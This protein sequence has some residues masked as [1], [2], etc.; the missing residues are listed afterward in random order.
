[1]ESGGDDS[2]QPLNPKR[3]NGSNTT[4]NGNAAESVVIQDANAN[5]WDS[6]Q[7]IA[8]ATELEEAN[9]KFKL[10]TPKECTSPFD[11]KFDKEKGI[12]EIPLIQM[13][14]PWKTVLENVIDFEEFTEDVET[15]ATAYVYFMFCLLKN[16]DDVRILRNKGIIQNKI[17]TEDDMAKFFMDL[18]R[19]SSG[20][21]NHF[22][23]KYLFDDINQHQQYLP[24]HW[25]TSLKGYGRKIKKNPLMSFTLLIFIFQ[26]IQVINTIISLI[27][28]IKS[29]TQ[30]C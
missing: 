2:Q 16:N 15:H 14:V 27:S 20:F 1:M 12:L 4:Q 17:G 5:N 18:W 13:T 30:A 6:I 10:L 23:R 19:K 7:P 29:F 3:Q 11:V 25:K 8:S 24:N 22:P 26:F 21:I 28:T 9:V